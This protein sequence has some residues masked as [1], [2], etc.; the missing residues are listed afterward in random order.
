MRKCSKC[1]ALKVDSEFYPK[2]SKCKACS[3]VVFREY[4]LKNKR[5]IYE[6]NKSWLYNRLAT[7]PAYKIIHYTRT[8]VRD[9]LKSKGWSKNKN[10]LE[11]VGCTAIEFKNH[12][13]AQFKPGM[14]WDNYGKAWHVDHILPISSFSECKLFEAFHYTNC[15]PLWAFENFKKSNKIS[16]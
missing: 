8:R 9:F 4:Y 12:I 14:T 3:A 7:D 13:E 15:Q 1:S 2:H 6:R 16:K 11:L 10:T 5:A